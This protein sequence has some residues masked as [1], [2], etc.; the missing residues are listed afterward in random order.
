[1]T[2]INKFLKQAGKFIIFAAVM[3]NAHGG[4]TDIA[5]GPLV[6]STTSSLAVKPNVFLMMDDSGSMGW[7]HMP[8]N[9]GDGGSNLPMTY[10]Y[11]A[12]RSSQCN[13]MYYEP[14]ITYTA[15]VKADGTS[16]PDATFTSAYPDGYNPGSAVNLSTSY[17]ATDSG[18]MSN[19]DTTGVTGYYYQYVGSQT[20]EFLKN[21]YV[22][23]SPFYMECSSN[24][25]TS[26]G[27]SLFYRVNLS[28]TAAT[29][30]Q[31]TATVTIS[32]TGVTASPYTSVNGIKVNGFQI[33]NAAAATASGISSSTMATN[34]AAKITLNGYSAIASGSVVTITGPV[35]AATYIPVLT[36]TNPPLT[37]ITVSGTGGGTGVN[38]SVSSIKMNGVELLNAPTATANGISSSAMASNI[39]AKITLNGYSATASGSVVTITSPAGPALAPTAPVLTVTNP[40]NGTMSFTSTVPLQFTPTLFP[41]TVTTAAQLTNFA[42]WYS[43]YHTRINMMKSATGLAFNTICPKTIPAKPCNYR[44]GMA[45]MNNNGGADFLNPDVFADSASPVSTQRT[46][47][48]AML[49]GTKANASTPLLDALS[50]AGLMYANKLPSNKLNTVT[51]KDPIQYSC[52]QN[53]TILSTDGF[54]NTTTNT[55]LSAN[56]GNSCSPSTTAVGNCDFTEPRP[57]YDGGTDTA[58]T[59]TPTTT[60]V[61]TQTVTPTITTWPW[62][63]TVTTVGAAASCT[64]TAAIPPSSTTGAPMTDNSTFKIA[65]GLSATNPDTTTPADCVSLGSNAW[66]CRGKNSGNSPVVSLASVTDASGTP[67]YLVSPGSNLGSSCT[68]D[69]TAFGSG[70]SSKKGA[71]PGTAAVMGYSVTTQTQAA[72]ETGTGGTSTTVNNATTTVT[73]TVTCINGLCGAPVITTVGPTSVQVGSTVITA[74]TSDDGPPPAG[75][76]NSAYTNTAPVPTSTSCPT[77]APAAGITTGP[78]QGTKATTNT[79]PVVTTPVSTTVTVGTPVLTANSSGGTSNTLS[80]VAEYYYVTDLRTATLNNCTSGSSGNTLCTTPDPATAT[81]PAIDPLNNVPT[82]GQDAASWQHMTTFTLGLGARGRMVFSPTYQT[83]GSGDFFAVKQGS[84]ADSTQSPPVCSWQPNGTVCNWPI[85][86]VSGVPENIDDLWHAAVDGRGTYYNATDPSSLSTGLSHALSGV[87]ARTGSSASASISNPN[88]STGDNF[89]FSSQY[90][91]Q[92]WDGQLIRQQ[93]DLNTGALSSVIDWDAGVLLDTNTTRKI[94]AF[95]ASSGNHLQSFNSTN[96]GSNANFTTPQ[97]NPLSQFCASG[98]TCLTAAQQT[99]ATGANLVAYLAGDRTNEGYPADLTKFY[100]QRLHLL[101]DIVDSQ[102]AYVKVP[103]LLYADSGYSDFVTAK[104]NRQSMI[105]VGANDGMLHAFYAS[106]PAPTASNP[107]STC[108]QMDPS[109]DVVTSGGT[110]VCGG[111]EAWAFI[112]TAVMPNLYKLADSNYANQHQYFVDGSP[113][114]TDICPTTPTTQCTGTTWKTILVGGLNGGGSSYYAMDITNPAVPVALWEFTNANLGLSYG[115]PQVVKL[116]GTGTGSYA[117]GTWVV[118]LTSGYNNTGTGADGKGHLFVLNAYT[119]ALLLDISTGAGNTTTPTPSGLS[120]IIAQVVNPSLDATVLQVYGGDLLGNL[121]RFDVNGNMGAAGYDAQLLAVLTGPAGLA[122]PITI[123]PE[124]GLINGHVVVY[125]GTGRYLGVSDI[126]GTNTTQM[127]PNSQTMYAIMDPLL[128]TTTPSVAIYTNPRT[129]GLPTPAGGLPFVQQTEFTSTCPQGAPATL[130]TFGQIIRTSTA[131]AV[132]IGNVN[133]GWYVDFPD[134]GERLNND[135]ALELGALA[136]NTNVPVASACTIGGNSYNY[137]LDYTTGSFLT[138]SVANITAAMAATLPS[139]QYTTSIDAAGNKTYTEGIVAA[140]HSGSLSTAPIFV[141]LP[142]G[143]KLI[144]TND[145]SGVLFC[146]AIN[147]PPPPGGARRVSWRQLFSQ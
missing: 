74:P 37:T 99:A 38:T 81:P 76:P 36:V 93:L 45:T 144:C 82:T 103:L 92:E 18:T 135:P 94:Y 78:T 112:P 21:Y 1:M 15:P 70:Y 30:A 131:K 127:A 146:R 109:G 55:T 14:T 75:P 20:T 105:Y 10:G 102:A 52:Q 111:Q 12:F 43:Y 123:K 5:Q 120:R 28:T 129:Y 58:T 100:R 87:T 62:T 106:D 49:Y 138:N 61:Q 143:T 53:F 72:T 11:Y 46:A 66:I 121:W 35:S 113:L 4:I 67:W 50:Q 80:D 145:S 86:N 91:T 137:V 57:L 44:V 118:L 34:I 51:A 85:P 132:S 133:S 95:S 8:D 3:A 17:Q 116:G 96:F 6:T 115:D 7:S 23:T 125:V 22:S 73:S 47:F 89:I 117:P 136:F 140:S 39:A 31:T 97:I 88:I 2:T 56:P 122:Q 27:Q 142:N 134:S 33:M 9:H 42:N 114:A 68:R 126:D 16:Y 71:C 79:T 59:A 130:C 128:T 24:I 104:A 83:D 108:N 19:Q 26:P 84:L 65:L 98:A 13:G 41:L 54:W 110:T 124:V 25:N 63:R 69:S 40:A 141:N 48:Y 139:G 90:I 29:S 107:T 60:V 119:G 147:P 32:G 101:G 64:H 77:S